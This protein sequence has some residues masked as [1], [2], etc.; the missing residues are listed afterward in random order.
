[1]EHPH[2]RDAGL[3]GAVCGCNIESV[4][5]SLCYR[6]RIYPNSRKGPPRVGD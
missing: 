6:D 5:R 1:M 2:I 3:Q 4:V